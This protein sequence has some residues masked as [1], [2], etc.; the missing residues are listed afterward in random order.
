MYII[1]YNV[2]IALNG[3]SKVR[4]LAGE[5]ILTIKKKTMETIKFKNE[6]QFNEYCNHLQIMGWTGSISSVH[7]TNGMVTATF[8]N[9]IF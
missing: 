5:Q 8:S 7:H 6:N 9:P 3:C 4:F 2:Y 1:Y